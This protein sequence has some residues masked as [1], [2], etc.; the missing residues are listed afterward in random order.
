[1]NH[2]I[3]LLLLVFTLIFI[4]GCIDVQYNQELNR[5]GTSNLE[6]MIEVPAMGAEMLDE[7]YNQTVYE[8]ENNANLTDVDVNVTLED[9]ALSYHFK[10]IDMSSQENLQIINDLSGSD[11]DVEDA[12]LNESHKYDKNVGI[13]STTYRYE[14]PISSM[15]DDN[16][17]ENESAS[18]NGTQPT[19]NMDLEELGEG[20]EEMMNVEYR[21]TVFGDI[22]ETN[23]NQVN[24]NTVSVDLID[25]PENVSVLYVEFEE[26]S[27]KSMWGIL[28]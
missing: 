22:V 25:L 10:N 16:S 27:F 15:D 4:T 28:D 12:Q 9:N 23:M 17:V 2:K 20:I 26:S 13:F 24:E 5:D 19:P 11:E 8:I 7:M 14:L 1:M 21:L 6:L 18:L 3:N